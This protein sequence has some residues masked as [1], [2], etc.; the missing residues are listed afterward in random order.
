MYVVEEGIFPRRVNF[1][2]TACRRVVVHSDAKIRFRS[3]LSTA[4]ALAW[5][6]ADMRLKAGDDLG[7]GWRLVR[8]VAAGA[9]AAIWDAERDGAAG[10]RAVVKVLNLRLE[11]DQPRAAERFAREAQKAMSI[12]SAHLPTVLAHG[13]APTRQPF[14]VMS[15]VEGTPLPRLLALRTRLQPAEVTR[16]LAQVAEGL[17]AAHA[18]DMCHHEVRA[19]NVLV[20]RDEPLEVCLLGLGVAKELRT[21]DETTRPNTAVGNLLDRS[22]EE[23]TGHAPFGPRTDLWSLGALV[24]LALTGVR[25]FEGDD[26][27]DV[28]DR[29]ARGAYTPL[30]EAMGRGAVLPRREAF[31]AWFAMALAYQPEAR[32]PRA[33]DMVAAWPLAAAAPPP[34]MFSIADD[35]DEA[36]LIRP[37]PLAD[38]DVG[39]P[40]SAPSGVRA[41]PRRPPPP[42][43]RPP[44]PS[45][46]P[47]SSWAPVPP[48]ASIPPEVPSSSEYLPAP[49]V[50]PGGPPPGTTASGRIAPAS[51]EAAL[52][53]RSRRAAWAAAATV[54]LAAG[55]LFGVSRAMR[56][57]ASSASGDAARL[58]WARVASELAHRGAHRSAP[59][60]APTSEV[61]PGDPMPSRAAT[62]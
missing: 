12:R 21:A 24:Y 34:T 10:G 2:A 3:P 7:N 62:R 31:D 20:T 16:L 52:R 35:D 17:G 54:V 22:P 26:L 28:R 43:R 8:R 37:S 5:R 57:N 38:E 53:R 14:L 58:G 49:L 48:R 41:A 11:P 55:G 36:T 50:R 23:L 19:D 1:D 9:I 4:A 30:E 51:A 32:F 60:P 42:P 18:A 46:R 25:P 29:I 44:P 56:R 39:T 27:A 59:A 6:S 61:P 45:R 13:L 15:R 33:S 40:V 47:S